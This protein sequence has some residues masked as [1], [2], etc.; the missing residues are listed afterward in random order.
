MWMQ[1]AAQ[2]WPEPETLELAIER[3]SC[4]L[5]AL[6]FD[7][8]HEAA[9]GNSCFDEESVMYYQNQAEKYNL[10]AQLCQKYIYGILELDEFC[11]L[12]VLADLKSFLVKIGHH[13]S[14]EV[15][16][17]FELNESNNDDADDN[18]EGVLEDSGVDVVY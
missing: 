7:S 17:K 18:K 15:L 1:Y 3:L 11:T 5:N 13:L 8:D 10:G 9:Y 2:Q 12:M 14:E 4:E 6:S 16:I